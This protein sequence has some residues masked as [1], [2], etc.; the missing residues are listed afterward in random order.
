MGFSLFVCVEKETPSCQKSEIDLRMKSVGL[1]GMGNA[2]LLCVRFV[3]RV[4]SRCG[5]SVWIN[6]DDDCSGSGD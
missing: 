4:V 6:D 5:V 1:G 3:G 2:R